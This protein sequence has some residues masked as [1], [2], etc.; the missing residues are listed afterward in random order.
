VEAEEESLRPIGEPCTRSAAC[1]TTFRSCMPVSARSASPCR[2]GRRRNALRAPRPR[3][4]PP[5]SGTPGRR[6]RPWPAAHGQAARAP[7]ARGLRVSP[8]RRDGGGGRPCAPHFAR[9][10]TVR[11]RPRNSFTPSPDPI[12]CRSRRR[13]PPAPRGRRAR[14]GGPAIGEDAPVVD[15][16]E[17]LSTRSPCGRRPPGR[18]RMPGL[19]PAPRTLRAGHPSLRGRS[20]RRRSAEVSADRRQFSCKCGALPANVGSRDAACTASFTTAVACALSSSSARMRS[21][22]SRLLP[23]SSSDFD[24][25]TALPTVPP[26]C[27]TATA[28]S[29]TSLC[30]PE[31]GNEPVDRRAVRSPAI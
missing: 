28:A 22:A 5:P 10:G 21:A 30:A 12:Q 13:R 1:S 19:L 8:G 26:K 29:S 17:H 6:S 24:R 11:R 4:S 31:C 7:A 23:R 25:L 3:R 14:R 9:A 2:A 15:A 20:G 18:W 27:A 16:A